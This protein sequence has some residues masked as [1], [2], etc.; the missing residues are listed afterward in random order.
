[1][2]LSDQTS[3]GGGVSGAF[4]KWIRRAGSR[5]TADPVSVR[6][7]SGSVVAGRA[8]SVFETRS[9][10]CNG[11]QMFMVNSG[12]RWPERMTTPV[13]KGMLVQRTIKARVRARV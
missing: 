3:F 5:G 9:N 13:V 6:I 1:M 11:W 8:I 2:K 10:V 7:N 12:S 4:L